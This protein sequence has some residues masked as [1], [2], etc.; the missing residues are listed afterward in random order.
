MDMGAVTKE[1]PKGIGLE[2]S[3][4]ITYKLNDRYQIQTIRAENHY[5]LHIVDQNLKPRIFSNLTQ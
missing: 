4:K 5:N 3:C 2:I 1:T